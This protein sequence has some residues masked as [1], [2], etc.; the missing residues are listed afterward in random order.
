MR[1]T[2]ISVATGPTHYREFLERQHQSLRR[3][4]FAGAIM[5]WTG[6]YPTYSPTHQEIPYA[7]KPWAFVAA[8]NADQDCVLWCDASV[9]AR[10]SLA[11]VFAEIERSGHVFF[12]NGFNVGQWCTDAALKAHGLTRDQAME[13]PDLT[14]CCMGLNLADHRGRAF[15]SEWLDAAKDG[16]S[17]IGD[18]KNDRGQCSADP[19]CQGHRHD[20]VIASI[21]AWRIGIP[22]RNAGPGGWLSY[23][24]DDLDASHCESICLVNG[25]P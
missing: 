18:W 19:R 1:N 25:R 14:G 11:P 5:H 20:Q 7:F 24:R 17:F 8:G 15:L 16:V 21:I 6:V 13:I 10:R 23:W 22:L 12:A 9:W 2:V 4:E 3:V